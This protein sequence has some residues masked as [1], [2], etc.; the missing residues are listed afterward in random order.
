[1]PGA[2][3]DRLGKASPKINELKVS[4]YLA[5]KRMILEQQIRNSVYSSIPMVGQSEM[6]LVGEKLASA[7]KQAVNAAQQSSSPMM[8]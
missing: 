4:P 8:I 6:E 5:M 2:H 1:M 7:R 3:T